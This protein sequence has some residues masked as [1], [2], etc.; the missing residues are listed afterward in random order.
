MNC[1]S[2]VNFF[3]ACQKP[4][5]GEGSSRK[6]GQPRPKYPLGSTAWDSR[7]LERLLLMFFLFAIL[8]FFTPVHTTRQIIIMCKHAFWEPLNL[9][10][11]LIQPI[12]GHHF[13]KLISP[14]HSEPSQV[15]IS[16]KRPKRIRNIWLIKILA[17]SFPS[18]TLKLI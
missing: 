14:P 8:F 6:K 2:I 4:C 12:R 11:T 15:D 10:E 17:A 9:T 7:R 3:L 13:F 16:L 18:Q 1:F 5:V